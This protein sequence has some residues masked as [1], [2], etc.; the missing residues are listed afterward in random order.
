MALGMLA[1]AVLSLPAL[2]LAAGAAHSHPHSAVNAA[3]PS[4]TLP[5]QPAPTA[6]HDRSSWHGE[7]QI[8]DA[9]QECT[10][11][12]YPPVTQ[13]VRST[14]PPITTL[15]RSVPLAD[16]GMNPHADRLVPR[17]L[18]DRRPLGSVRPSHPR[19][20][21]P[22]KR[23]PNPLSPR[24]MISSPARALN[25]SKHQTNHRG[26]S[27]DDKALFRALNATIPAIAPRGDRAGNF[28]GVVYGAFA[29]RF[30]DASR[31]NRAEA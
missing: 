30:S 1:A 29:P 3:A 24:P 26:I 12:N 23:T 2:A 17:H 27:E 21:P 28:T 16:L 7:A 14:L 13:I 4:T 18:E 19:I 25:F 9:T 22:R 8:K 5:R 10:Y 20:P 31:A 15:S 11:Y 6:A